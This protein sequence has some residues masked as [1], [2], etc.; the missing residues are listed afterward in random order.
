[1]RCSRPLRARRAPA[2]R[3]P[4]SS[5][6]W[7]A[8]RPSGSASSALVLARPGRPGARCCSGSCRSSPRA[9]GAR[10]SRP[11]PR[12]ARRRASSRSLALAV[13]NAVRA[14]D[15]TVVRGG[16]GVAPLPHVR[17]RPHRRAR[18]TATASAELARAVVARASPE[19][20]V[21][22]A[23][24]RPRDVLLVG[25]PPDARRPDRP[26]RPDVG[27]GRRL[28][29]PRPR[30]ARGDPRAPGNICARRR[31]A[32]CGGCSCGR[33]TRPVE[34]AAA[35]PVRRAPSQP[36]ARRRPRP[37]PTTSRSR[38][39]ARRRTSRR[40][41]GGSARCGRRRPSTRSSSGTRATRRGGRARPDGRTAP[42]RAPRP[43]ASARRSSRWSTT[44]RVSIRGPSCGSSS[45][46]RRRSGA[47][48]G[49]SR[50]RR[51]SPP[52]RSS[53]MVATSLAVYAVAE[54]SVP[55]VP[56]FVLLATAGVFGRRSA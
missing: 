56:A 53:C 35:S 9:A 14:D 8:R 16:V 50:S 52:R 4:S 55:V 10:A 36:A 43:R 30:R 2:R 19:R 38:H 7:R 25:E 39:R 22:V 28:P 41:T 17:R 44:S 15:F 37:R 27:L 40:P 13:H 54:Y 5:R 3:V 29:S 24:H 23:R 34:T 32:T 26:L 20:A 45:V 46:S 12:F 11:R 1:M 6:R 47:A 49:A 18:T 51:C 33:S 42:R 21:P 31:A 48:R